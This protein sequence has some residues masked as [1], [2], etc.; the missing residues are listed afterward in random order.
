GGEPAGAHARRP[1]GGACG[2]APPTDGGA[3]L[4]REAA[5]VAYRRRSGLRARRPRASKSPRI[6]AKTAR[7]WRSRRRAVGDVA[8][9]YDRAPRAQKTRKVAY[10]R[11]SGLRARRPRARKS[12]RIHATTA[13]MWRSRRRAVG[14]VA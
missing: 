5:E 3:P 10:R 2:A 14:D 1:R 12:P 11:R 8:P 7:I 6:H 4:E 13:R 9:T